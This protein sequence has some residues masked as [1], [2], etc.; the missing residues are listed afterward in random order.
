MGI[1]E[2]HAFE[3][4]GKGGADITTRVGETRQN[5]KNCWGKKSDSTDSLHTRETRLLLQT[6]PELF[7]AFRRVQNVNPRR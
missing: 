3:K 7:G 4:N 1:E 2:V 6:I 5:E